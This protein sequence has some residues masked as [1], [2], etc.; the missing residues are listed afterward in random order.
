MFAGKAQEQAK[1]KIRE[2]VN[3][4]LQGNTIPED[5]RKQGKSLL[6]DLLGR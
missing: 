5:L 1:Q 2:T 4:L 6:K 3:D